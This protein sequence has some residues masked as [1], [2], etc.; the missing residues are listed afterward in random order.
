M[1]VV[2]KWVAAGSSAAVFAGGLFLGVPTAAAAPGEAACLQAS[3]QFEAA[4]A[5]AGI[6]EATVAQLESFAEAAA[7]AEAAYIALVE[8]A[9]AGMVAELEEAEVNLEDAIAATAAAEDALEEAQG[10]GDPA[11]LAEAKAA[12]E[13][14]EDAEDNAQQAVDDLTAAY[15]AAITAPEILEAENA[16]NAAV[17]EFE[18]VLSTVTLNETSAANLMGLFEA[19][20]AACN[21]DAIGVD[22]VGTPPGNTVPTATNQVSSTPVGGGTVTVATNK[23]LNV[24]TAA[25]VEPAT[26]PGLALLAGLLAAGIAVPSTVAMRMRRL[27]RS[28]K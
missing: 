19:F 9:T 14:A 21:P 3:T 8:A 25:E 10:S 24:Q 20:L 23:G 1:T 15:E 13:A 17:A 5:A 7:A 12:K 4:L 22:P 16:L 18:T 2:S 26:H 28:R 11:V 27:E 6:T